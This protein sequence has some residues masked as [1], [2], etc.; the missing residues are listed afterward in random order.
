MCWIWRYSLLC[1]LSATFASKVDNFHLELN[2]ISLSNG[3][4]FHLNLKQELLMRFF[5]GFICYGN[6]SS[7]ESREQTKI[8]MRGTSRITSSRFNAV[9]TSTD[10]APVDN[11]CDHNATLFH[12]H[13][14]QC[15]LNLKL[16]LISV[17]LSFHF[18]N[19]TFT[20]NIR[21]L[22]SRPKTSK[23]RQCSGKL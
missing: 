15:Y 20:L 17:P 12:L 2:K 7:D 14:T 18:H 22:P 13:V 11:L 4:K 6:N 19:F 5:T 1:E 9:S 21:K 16:W 23:R 10:K 3:V 8:L